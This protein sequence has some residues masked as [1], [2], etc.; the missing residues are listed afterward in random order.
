MASGVGENVILNALVSDQLI[1]RES[2]RVVQLADLMLIDLEKEGPKPDD[3][4][5]CVWS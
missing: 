5:L 3:S 1:I 2:R 4:T